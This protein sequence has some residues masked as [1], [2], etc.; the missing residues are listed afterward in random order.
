MVYAV[1]ML[2]IMQI[3]SLVGLFVLWG[4]RN[5]VFFALN[6][7]N[8]ENLRAARALKA[9]ESQRI[10]AFKLQMETREAGDA[11]LSATIEGIHQKLEAKIKSFD[12]AACAHVDRLDLADAELS[13]TIEGMNQRLLTLE[14]K[15]PKMVARPKKVNFRQ[16]RDAA[17][18]ASEPKEDNES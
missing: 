15:Q 1:I 18:R 10:S 13:A 7:L 3:V 14:G 6:K 16:F 12:G 8:D 17:E 11:E 5:K 9:E 4:N 2:G